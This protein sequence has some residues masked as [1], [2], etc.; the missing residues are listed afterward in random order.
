ML[1]RSEATVDAKGVSLSIMPK[2]QNFFVG[3]L[4]F[5]WCAGGLLRQAFR[6]PRYEENSFA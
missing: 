4:R 2:G 5:F 1:E 3:F 6:A